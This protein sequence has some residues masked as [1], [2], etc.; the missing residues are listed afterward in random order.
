MDQMEPLKNNAMVPTPERNHDVENDSTFAE[1][2]RKKPVLVNES[3]E[4]HG[5]VASL[6][7]TQFIPTPT[8]DTARPAKMVTILPPN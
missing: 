6:Q 8:A 4:P 5:S 2:K 3:S 7:Q 1:T